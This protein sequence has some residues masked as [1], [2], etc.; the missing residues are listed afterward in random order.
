MSIKR[1]LVLNLCLVLKPF[2]KSTPDY[3]LRFNFQ[4]CTVFCFS[5]KERLKYYT[6]SSYLIYGQQNRK[7]NFSLGRSALLKDRETHNPSFFFLHFCLNEYFM[8]L[9]SA[10]FFKKK[11]L[12][13]LVSS[14]IDAI[15][16]S[17]V[18][19]GVSFHYQFV[20]DSEC[21][22]NFHSQ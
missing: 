18:G 22:F 13:C 8:K 4:I 7:T 21:P 3:Y 11:V 5:S 2:V 12:S 20:H 17:T 14:K 6:C 19:S 16:K 9:I 1:I 15:L 10:F